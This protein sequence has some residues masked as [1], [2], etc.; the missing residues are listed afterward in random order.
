MP[1]PPDYAPS[2]LGICVARLERSLRFYCDGLGFEKAETYAVGNEYRAGLEAEGE[3]DLVS[4]FVRK[5]ALALEL[6]AWRS[7][8]AAGRP[9]TRRNEL[10]FT[11]LSFVVA[12]VDA[13]ARHLVS[14]GGTL[15]SATRT[16]RGDPKAVQIVFVADPD[17]VR[18]ELMST[19]A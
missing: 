19:P 6:L 3:V 14:C 13:A 16:G 15:L 5:D 18:V 7:P 9:S 12:D 2:H 11:H 17:G 8:G 1:K 10:G 4:Q